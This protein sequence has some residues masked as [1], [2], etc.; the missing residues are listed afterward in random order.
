MSKVNVTLGAGMLALL[1]AVASPAPA[2]Q[3]D[4]KGGFDGFLTDFKKNRL[5][6]K[7]PTDKRVQK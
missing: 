3:C 5:D 2:A 1:T 7:P 6:G 4:H